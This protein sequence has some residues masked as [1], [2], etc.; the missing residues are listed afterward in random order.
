MNDNVYDKL[1]AEILKS[2]TQFPGGNFQNIYAGKIADLA[3]KLD[4]RL[5]DRLVYQ[6]MQAMQKKGL[7]YSYNRGWYPGEK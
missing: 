6:R 3:S 5:A 2:I 4:P 7:I 1:D